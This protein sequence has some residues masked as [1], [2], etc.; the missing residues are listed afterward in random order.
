MDWIILAQD[1]AQWRADMNTIMKLCVPL[2]ASNSL[3]TLT[4]IRMSK[5]ALFHGVDQRLLL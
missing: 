4:A 1:R 3:N 5:R 2:N